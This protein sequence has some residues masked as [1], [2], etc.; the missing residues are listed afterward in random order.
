MLFCLIG[1]HEYFLHSMAVTH[2]DKFISYLDSRVEVCC[3]LNDVLSSSRAVVLKK[4]R[5]IPLLSVWFVRIREETV[6]I[7]VNVFSQNF[8]VGLE[9]NQ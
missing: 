3:S 9:E 4:K 5:L 2:T 6:I 1:R 7:D 8:S